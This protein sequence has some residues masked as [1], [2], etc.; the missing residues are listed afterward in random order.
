M[1]GLYS[2]A[3]VTPVVKAAMSGQ[4]EILMTMANSNQAWKSRCARAEHVRNIVRFSYLFH[5]HT[6]PLSAQQLSIFAFL[7]P[8]TDMPNGG[9]AQV[10]WMLDSDALSL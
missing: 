2:I 6:K 9:F 10:V 8:E 5:G 1:L 3:G 7:L 4:A